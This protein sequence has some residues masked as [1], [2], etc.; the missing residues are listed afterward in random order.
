M[1]IRE[2]TQLIIKYRIMS[3][4]VATASILAGRYQQAKTHED[5]HKP[6]ECHDSEDDNPTA[7]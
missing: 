3:F 5:R 4:T 2:S 6:P 1:G 7:H